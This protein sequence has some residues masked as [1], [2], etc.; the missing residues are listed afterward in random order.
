MGTNLRAP[1]LRSAQDSSER[2]E[3]LMGVHGCPHTGQTHVA[4][5]S[6]VAPW[7]AD[8]RNTCLT[9]E[10][11][12]QMSIPE[13]TKSPTV[14]THG[15]H[16]Q[17]PSFLFSADHAV[18]EHRFLIKCTKRQASNQQLRAAYWKPSLFFVT[19]LSKPPWGGY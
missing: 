5:G 7:P 2:P 16:L 14:V 11:H 6:A 18:T 9:E 4:G 17:F 12:R 15:T 13:K 19:R 3:K 10:N 1:A 8:P